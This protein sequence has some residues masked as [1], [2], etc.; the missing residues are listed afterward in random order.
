[1]DD[2]E[3]LAGILKRLSSE[4]GRRFDAGEFWARFRI[5][6]AVYFLKVM[7]HPGLARYRYDLYLR[8]P[9]SPDLT[10]AYYAIEAWGPGE[11]AR[12]TPAAISPAALSVLKDAIAEG[13]WFMETVVTL[14]S[15]AS[16]EHTTKGE[17][18]EIA[19]RLK[20]ARE[21]YFER[22]W[23]FLCDRGLL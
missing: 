12:V 8:G 5:Q 23:A 1:M 6:K 21:P 17:T 10:K 7:G 3:R 20:P 14:H 19:R 2:L 9:Y 13:E 4:T 22:A 15:I 18:F 16:S 11:R